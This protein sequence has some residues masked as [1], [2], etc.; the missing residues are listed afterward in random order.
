MARC[1]MRFGRGPSLN[2]PE[3]G[4]DSSAFLD[5]LHDGDARGGAEVGFRTGAG[6]RHGEIETQGGE[7]Q[8]ANSGPGRS[9]GSKDFP[10]GDL[11][12]WPA[13]NGTRWL[14]RRERGHDRG[15]DGVK[16]R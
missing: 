2:G 1:L 9:G 16:S 7:S 10:D 3:I 6:N 4:K 13:V 5:R 14:C 15:A 12:P 8:D 11:P